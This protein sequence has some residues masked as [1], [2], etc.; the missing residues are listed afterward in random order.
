LFASPKLALL[1]L[2][3]QVLALKAQIDSAEAAMNELLYEL[4]GLTADE[5]KLVEA[6]RT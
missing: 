6:A 1:P 3:A 4:Y 2:D 5:R